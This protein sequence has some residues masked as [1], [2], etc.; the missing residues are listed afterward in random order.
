MK[1]KGVILVLV[2]AVVFST[3]GLFTKGVS[4]DAWSVIFWRGLF[5]A[6]F[7]FVYILLKGT[8][9]SETLRMG[10]SGLSDL[11]GYNFKPGGSIWCR[12]NS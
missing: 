1:L 6:I 3:A 12:F 7:S 11:I 10:K 9:K 8:L 5:A 4:A 2:S